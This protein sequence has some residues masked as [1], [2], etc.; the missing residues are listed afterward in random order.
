MQVHLLCLLHLFVVE[1][2]VLVRVIGAAEVGGCLLLHTDVSFRVEG[3]SVVDHEV[4][5]L[6]FRLLFVYTLLELV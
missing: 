6:F 5:S 4:A 3:A 2:G 1:D